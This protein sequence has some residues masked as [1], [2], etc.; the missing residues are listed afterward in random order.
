MLPRFTVALIVLSILSS[1]VSLHL[2]DSTEAQIAALVAQQKSFED[3]FSVLLNNV[4][5]VEKQ[6]QQSNNTDDKIQILEKAIV[7][8]RE[9][10]F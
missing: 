8:E 2:L 9:V 1:T 7:S 6:I 5:E 4:T 3:T 10:T